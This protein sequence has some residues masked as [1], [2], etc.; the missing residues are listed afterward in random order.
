MPADSLPRDP[1][2]AFDA[3]AEIYDRV[4]PSYPDALFGELFSHFDG[5]V[6]V[7]EVGPGTG[8]ATRSLLTRGATVV[9]AEPG[10]RLAE[11]LR[12]NFADDERLTVVN[13]RFEEVADAAPFDLVFAATSFHWT[14]PATRLQL[15]HDALRPGGAIAVVSTNQVRSD[16][17]RGY[18]DRC[19]PVYQKY[20]P[21]ETREVTPDPE[22]VVPPDFGELEESP[23]FGTP[24]LRRYRWDQTYSTAQYGDLLRSYSGTNMMEP[25][26]REGLVTELCALA[27]AEFGGAVTRP[28][29]ITL[30]MAFR[31]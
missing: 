21:N 20:F 5:A 12:R 28:L 15:A 26:P 19:Q 23:L 29:V 7:L 18:F 22:N 24:E 17:D 14:D 4:R 1:G 25:E 11:V 2:L 6:R 10:P 27:D 3:A 31:D 16:A 30:T 9:A 8:Q 13:A